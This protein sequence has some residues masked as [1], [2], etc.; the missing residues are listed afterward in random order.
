MCLIFGLW[1]FF[2]ASTDIK[3]AVDHAE[4]EVCRQSVDG[5]AQEM[6]VSRRLA[7]ESSKSLLELHYPKP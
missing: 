7:R 4:F 6:I 5:A 2:G 3:S 1:L